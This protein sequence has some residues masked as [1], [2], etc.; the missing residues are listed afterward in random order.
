MLSTKRKYLKYLTGLCGGLLSGLSLFADTS[1]TFEI[2]NG[3]TIN[4][5]DANNLKQ[6]LWKIFNHMK[7][8]P[9]YKPDQVVEEGYYKDSRKVGIWRRYY[10]NGNIKDEIEYNNNR[11]SGKY[12][13]Y[14]ENGVLQEEGEWKNNRNVGTFKRYYENGNIS[15]EFS[16]NESGKREGTQKYYY[17][18]GQLMIEGEWKEGKE[19][20]V[21]KEY[22]ENGDLKAEKFFADGQLDPEKTKTYEPKKPIE[23]KKEEPA[24]VANVVVKKEEEK[25]NIGA[26]DGNGYA[27]LYNL[28]KQI[29]KDGIFKNYKLIDGKWYKYD[30][31]GILIKIEIYKNGRY[32]GDGV[33]EEK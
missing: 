25:P 30:E 16:F 22:Y 10:P 5:V 3:D 32:V 8:L 14:Y 26:F 15:Q 11:P 2:Y 31:N 24:P 27:K 1:Q 4:Y 33:I 29:S 18:N 21:L 13:I 7:N 23:V 9:G 28:N 20:G 6:G 12:K 17:E 19:S